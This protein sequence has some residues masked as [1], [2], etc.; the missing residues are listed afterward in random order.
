VG[1]FEELIEI[2]L[3][4]VCDNN[5]LLIGLLQVIAKPVQHEPLYTTVYF[6]SP[7]ILLLI[8]D[9]PLSAKEK[10][11]IKNILYCKIL[12][13][14]MW[15]QVVTRLDLAFVVSLLTYFAHKPGKAY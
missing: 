8:E 5:S 3:N 2:W 13:S 4:E 9:C 14:L 6:F 1:I 10:N 15:L 12:G 11:K 7:G